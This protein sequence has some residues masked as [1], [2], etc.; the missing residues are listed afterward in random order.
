MRGKAISSGERNI[1]LNSKNIQVNVFRHFKTEN[2]SLNENAVNTFHLRISVR[3][4]R[5]TGKTQRNKDFFSI[6]DF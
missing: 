3:G 1:I 4:Q 2:F 6:N 5:A